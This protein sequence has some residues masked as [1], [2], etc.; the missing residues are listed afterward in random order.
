MK[1]EVLL[2]SGG[3]DS[4]ILAHMYPFAK[5][6]YIDSGARYTEKEL[7]KIYLTPRFNGDKTEITVLRGVVD[8]SQYERE[9]AI[10]PARNL[11]LATIAS[12][13]GDT[14][15]LAATAGDKSTDKDD[16]FTSL[17][18]KTLSH[19][20]DCD[21]FERGRIKVLL[22]TKE[23]TKSKLVRW[24]V[25]KGYSIGN[26]INTVSCYSEEKG[27]CGK[28]KACLR[29]WVALKD[30]NIHGVKFNTHPRDYDWSS[31]IAK[32]QSKKG[33]RCPEEDM[34]TL[35]VLEKEGLL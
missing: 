32:I 8:L 29:K 16:L 31:I 9:D 22:P 4:Y 30:N 17:T 18:G 11:I 1:K 20:Y 13:Y 14:V 23:W 24:Y 21:H 27:H 7:S 12:F 10:V 6:L 35:D 5:L 19:I 2:Y 25:E 33:W 15:L 28:C 34:Y 3:M 26:L